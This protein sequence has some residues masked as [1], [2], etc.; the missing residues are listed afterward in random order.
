MKKLVSD[1]RTVY[2]SLS[3][4]AVVFLRSARV[5][6]ATRSIAGTSFNA[7]AP[8]HLTSALMLPVVCGRIRSMSRLGAIP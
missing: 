1:G 2:P 3:S 5:D 7:A 4:S 6:E 8:A